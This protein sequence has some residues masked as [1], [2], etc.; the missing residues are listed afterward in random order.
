MK[1]RIL[2]IFTCLFIIACVITSCLDS[3]EIEYQYSAN[4][5]I[6]AFSISDIETEYSAIV[7]GKDTTLIATVTGENYPFVIDQN[8]GLIYNL[9]SLPVGTNVSKV[10][11]EITADGYIFIAAETDSIWEEG[12]S[13][14]FNKPIQFKV[15]SAQG[16]YGRTYTAKVNVHQQEP[17][18]M[19]WNKLTGN[20]STTIQRQKA[21]YFKQQ[22]IVFSEETISLFCIC[23]CFSIIC[24]IS[25][26]S[27]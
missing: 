12:D 26:I 27:S 6:T 2:N 21:V 23:P 10:V 11:P 9:D 8:L 15:M 4:A 19:S 20:F 1:L 13:L 14:D 17:K 24:G 7:D 18:E 5:S 16:N 22:I 25:A 3:E